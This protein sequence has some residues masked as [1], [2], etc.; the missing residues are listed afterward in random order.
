MYKIYFIFFFYFVKVTRN[1][2]LPSLGMG[3]REAEYAD[4]DEMRLF[5]DSVLVMIAMV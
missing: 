3:D 2:P 1:S 5:Y 4:I